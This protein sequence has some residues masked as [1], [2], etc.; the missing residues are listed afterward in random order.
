MAKLADPAW[1]TWDLTVQIQAR[2]G[3]SDIDV[4]G[5]RFASGAVVGRG[6]L[7]D[8]AAARVACVGTFV[9]TNSGTVEFVSQPGMEHGQAY[10]AAG[11][12]LDA[13]AIEAAERSL[14]AR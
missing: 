10:G 11:F 3:A 13:N 9:A 6:F 4:A 7:V 5:K 14:V 2:Q 8:Y 12:D 1:W